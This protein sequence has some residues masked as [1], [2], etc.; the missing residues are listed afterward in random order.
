MSFWEKATNSVSFFLFRVLNDED[1][2]LGKSDKVIIDF[3][4][5]ASVPP[6]QK[7]KKA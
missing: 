7:D 5:K 1:G 2:G 6:T 4:K 3:S